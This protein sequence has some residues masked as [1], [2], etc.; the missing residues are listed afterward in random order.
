MYR[1]MKVDNVGVKDKENNLIKLVYFLDFIEFIQ[2]IFLRSKIKLNLKVYRVAVYIYL[3]DRK[4][5]DRVRLFVSYGWVGRRIYEEYYLI[6]RGLQGYGSK[7]ERRRFV[8]ILIIVLYYQLGGGGR[9]DEII[10]YSIGSYQELQFFYL[11]LGVFLEKE[12]INQVIK[13]RVLIE[14]EKKEFF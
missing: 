13:I 9:G 5:Q 7:G 10:Y 14:K 6:F 2:K 1:I 12:D 8:L 4:S 3:L 11:V